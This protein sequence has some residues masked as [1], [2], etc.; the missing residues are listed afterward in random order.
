VRRRHHNTDGRRQIQR[1]KTRVQVAC[2]ARRRGVPPI[3]SAIEKGRLLH[4]VW[5]ARHR[6][7]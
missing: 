2:M 3:V 1:G 5:R 4:D 6:H 7:V